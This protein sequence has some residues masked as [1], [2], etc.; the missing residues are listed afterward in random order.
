MKRLTGIVVL[1]VASAFA[2]AADAPAPIKPFNG[3]D[4]TGW[5]PNGDKAKSKW[6]VGAAK[7]DPA[8]PSKITAESG[9]TDLVNTGKAMDIYTEQ[10]FDDVIVKCET[11]TPKGSNSGI[12]LMG[13]YEV[14]VCDSTAKTGGYTTGDHGAIYGVSAPKD[15]KYNKTGV[16]DKFEIHFQ[17]PR[18]DADGKKTANAKFLKVILNDVVIQEN[19]EVKKPTGSELNPKESAKGPLMF[20]GN[21]GPVGIR[22]IEITPVVP[23]K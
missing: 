21:H 9:G 1:L 4:L 23:S 10:T 14:Q 15:P 3:K 12:Y 7:L 5:I 8:D 2:F 17:A 20:Q 16:W 13:E 6:T 11:L 18:F 19:V 22:N